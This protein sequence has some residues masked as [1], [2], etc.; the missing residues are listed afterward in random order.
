M[1]TPIRSN[2]STIEKLADTTDRN[3][4]NIWQEI[5]NIKEKNR[6]LESRVTALENRS[7]K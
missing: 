4:Y 5:A 3:M 1:N 6:I 7:N 2:N